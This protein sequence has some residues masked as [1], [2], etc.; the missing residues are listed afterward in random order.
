MSDFFNIGDSLCPKDTL[1]LQIPG[2]E[3]DNF[4]LK[5]NR[6]AQQ[7]YDERRP[8]RNPFFFFRGARGR[9]SGYTTVAR[10]GKFSFS[11]LRERNRAAA[12]SFLSVANTQELQLEPDGRVAMGLGNASVYETSITLHHIYGI[13]YLRAS[14]IKG[15][16]RSWIIQSVFM[17]EQEGDQSDEQAKAN[18]KAAEE[19]A[20]DDLDFSRI[21]G[22]TANNDNHKERKAR[23]GKLVFF[24]AFPIK[25]PSIEVDVMNPHYGGYYGQNKPPTDT[26]SPIPVF[27]LT[28]AKTP[29]YFLFGSQDADWR[30]W[31]I[32]GKTLETYFEE[33]LSINGI[34]AKTAI[35]Y[36]HFSKTDHS[37]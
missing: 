22:C 28:T 21:F 35:G 25:T 23:Q 24:D 36:G 30:N 13:P 26:M 33:A 32:E 8:D 3:V 31:K 2:R 11:E 5:L 17:K 18:A 37:H 29:F 15:V 34:G 10:F 6:F 20:M 4:E 14:S 16:V 12:H 19:K 1:D 9:D 27:F 7:R